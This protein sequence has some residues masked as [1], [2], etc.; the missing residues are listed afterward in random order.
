MFIIIMSRQLITEPPEL[1]AVSRISHIREMRAQL[2]MYQ[3]YD[4]QC[5]I[6]TNLVVCFVA[7]GVFVMF[8]FY[9]Q[10]N[11]NKWNAFE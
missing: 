2:H 7:I 5:N 11:F 9:F 6:F 1:N 3:I 8:L 10:S 4:A